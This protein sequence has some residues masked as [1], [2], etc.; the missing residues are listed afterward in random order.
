MC[1]VLSDFAHYRF[2]LVLQI[3][4]QVWKIGSYSLCKAVYT[5]ANDNVLFNHFQIY[6]NLKVVIKIWKFKKLFAKL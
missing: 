2:C 6:Q 4:S 3:S 5:I 1:D